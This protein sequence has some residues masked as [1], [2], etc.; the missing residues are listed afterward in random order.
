[1]KNLLFVFLFFTST[2]Y[3]QELTKTERII[4]NSYYLV[5]M[6]RA[7]VNDTLM[8]ENLY[9]ALRDN[10]YTSL[11]EYFDFFYGSPEDAYKL[12]CE[13][14]KFSEYDP[15]TS[16][17]IN[18]YYASSLINGKIKFVRI[19]DEDMLLYHNFRAKTIQYLKDNLTEWCNKNGYQIIF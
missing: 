7:Y 15:G 18:G 17:K 9:I 3:S 13:I 6:N 1:M 4:G 8:S 11:V 14:E 5:A 12:V 19:Y 2:V 16:G 10:K